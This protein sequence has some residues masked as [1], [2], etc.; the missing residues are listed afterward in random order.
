MLEVIPNS[1]AHKLGLESKKDYILGSQNISINDVGTLE[2]II[3]S[4]KRTELF[5]FNSK[6]RKVRT[7]I[8]ENCK[9]FGCTVGEGMIN[10]IKNIEPEPEK[11]EPEE[12]KVVV[13]I[14]QKPE[15]EIPPP[16][17]VK[18]V[19]EKVK[20]VGTVNILPPPSIYDLSMEGLTFQPRV[21]LSKYI[22]IN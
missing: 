8:I 21:L 18:I 4:N 13:T 11:H 22:L 20:I 3:L 2:S 10:S 14:L 19:K 1:T 6:T 15:I 5:V 16:P 12:E 9:E 17:P 7:I